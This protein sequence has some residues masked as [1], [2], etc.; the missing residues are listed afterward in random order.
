MKCRGIEIEP[1]EFSGCAGGAD[2]PVCHG[3][4]I[5]TPCG[6]EVRVQ[7][8]D[9]ERQQWRWECQREQRHRGTH[10]ASNGVRTFEWQTYD[11][12]IPANAE[13]EVRRNAVTSTGFWRMKSE[14]AK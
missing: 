4:N 12:V 5:E 8:P 7:D 13:R 2:C 11:C 10:L 3:T 6:H 14:E 9:D 1:L